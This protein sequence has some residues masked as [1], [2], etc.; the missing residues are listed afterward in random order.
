MGCSGAEAQSHRDAKRRPHLELRAQHEPPRQVAEEQAIPVNHHRAARLREPV[1]DEQPLVVECRVAEGHAYRRL[2]R[3]L[4]ERRNRPFH[5]PMPRGYTVA[6]A[7]YSS[8]TW[9][10][11]AEA[12]VVMKGERARAK[13][14]VQWAQRA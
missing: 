7:L 3:G 9:P 14:M 12:S 1:G 8:H 5:V 13:A 6:E 10:G 4:V 2:R 11:S